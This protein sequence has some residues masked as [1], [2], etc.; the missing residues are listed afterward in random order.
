MMAS[1]LIAAHAFLGEA[2]IIAFIWVFV[3]LLNPDKRRVDRAKFAAFLGVVFFFLSWASGGFYYV[4]QY[5]L[6]IKPIIKEG[7]QPWAHLIFMEVKEHIF[8]FLPFLS[9]LTLSILNKYDNELL[10][11]KRIKKSVLALCIAIIIIG[12]LMAGMGYLISTGYRV[13]L[14]AKGA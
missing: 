5:G 9:I 14:E 8:F 10:N 1:P 2:G 13:A 11:D 4:S 3:E 6:E 7:P 12:G